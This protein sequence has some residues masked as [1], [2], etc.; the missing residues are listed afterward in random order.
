M[1]GPG[2]R[3]H[4]HFIRRLN[5]LPGHVLGLI[6]W[7][8]FP[9]LRAGIPFNGQ[10]RRLERF[11]E[12][13]AR[14]DLKAIV[15]TGTFRGLTTVCMR[16]AS[17]LPVYTVESS[18]RAYCFA[19]RRFGDDEGIDNTLGDSRT[20]LK[21]LL[22]ETL[23]PDDPVLF[24]LDAHGESDLPLAEEL[25]IIAAGSRDPVVMIDDFQVPDD[26][27]YAHGGY[28]PGKQLV[29][30]YLPRCFRDEFRFCWPAAPSKTET[31]SRRGCLVACRHHSSHR[32]DLVSSLRPHVG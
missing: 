25:G 17:N 7:H 9:E 26:P 12:L 4:L 15:E 16:R 29:L 31:G 30:E 23:G 1:S 6:D 27:G 2:L 8:L 18:R 28:G 10:S 21:R 32:L 5:W 11:R 13:I 24:Y 22:S 20:F 19:D 3:R 14:C